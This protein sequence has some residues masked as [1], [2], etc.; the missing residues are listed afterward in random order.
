MDTKFESISNNNI[1]MS[2]I[3]FKLNG[4]FLILLVVFGNYIG[5]LLPC[6]LQTLLTRHIYAKHILIIFLIYYT[7]HMNDKSYTSPLELLKYTLMIYALFLLFSKQN[8]YIALI[9]LILLGLEY[10]N[11]SIITYNINSS[12]PTSINIDI[13][14]KIN[15]IFNYLIFILLLLGF[16]FYFIKQ[17][18]DHKKDW[19]IIKFIFGSIK[20]TNK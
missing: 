5:Q 3:Q 8:I 19:S 10:I 16:I 1:I 14:D 20:C 6:N 17:R 18:K 4:V 9:V 12:H 15:R 11:Y 2:D 13:L 7:V